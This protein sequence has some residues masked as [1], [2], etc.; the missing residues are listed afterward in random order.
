MEPAN[1]YYDGERD[2]DRDDAVDVWRNQEQFASLF[3]AVHAELDS[4]QTNTW[5][6]A[7]TVSLRIAVGRDLHWQL[8]NSSTDVQRLTVA[9]RQCIFRT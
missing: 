4:C 8:M 2:N 1:E 5:Q 9:S 7:V 3:T 6:W